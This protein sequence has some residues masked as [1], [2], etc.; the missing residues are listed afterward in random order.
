MVIN[1]I[2]EKFKNK[3]IALVYGQSIEGCGVTKVGAEIQKWCKQH[4]IQAD[5]YSYDERKY[6]RRDVHDVDF[7]SFEKDD[8]GN[9]VK[10]LNQYDIVM[11][12][13]YP[14]KKFPNESIKAFYEDLI[15]NINCIK[16]GFMHEIN[17]TNVDKIPFLVGIMNQM[18]LIYNF[19]QKT[20][21]S[22]NISKLLPSKDLGERV[23]KFSMLF[24]F[25][26]LKKY[27]DKISLNDKE[28]KLMY[29]G[30]W[31]TM[32]DP[33]R[34]LE[35]APILYNKDSN[36]KLE[37]CGLERSIGAYHDIFKQDNCLDKTRKKDPD[38][39][40]E[41]AVPVYGPYKYEEGMEKLA[42]SLFGCSFYRLPRTPENYG[43]RMEYTQIEIIAAGSIPVFDKHWGENNYIK[44]G[45]RFI[46]IP[47]SAIYSDKEDLEGTVNKLIE[48]ANDK[49]LQE[50]YRK[51]SYEIAKQ[52]F[53]INIVLPEILNHILEKGI[54]KNK[55]K[56]D[57]KLI[58]NLTSDC[59]DNEEFLK[60]F[61]EQKNKGEIV[62]M[63]IR[64]L[65][66]DNEVCVLGG[67]SG[68]K[69][70]KI[71]KFKKK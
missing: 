27:R 9:I 21:F 33:R 56:N 48:V 63:G 38:E 7:I 55:F 44:D 24:D 19:S 35:M 60:I 15:K 58:L 20:W 69:E 46:D 49:E 54:D 12:H 50:K 29:I 45:Q 57:D 10:E 11:F 26:E 65:G 25:D 41:N 3:K 6:N 42:N 61:N 2:M 22:Q 53:D 14:A 5:I 39:I 17:K 30:R 1:L 67:K 64:E 23:C 28:K 70:V 66:R 16:V 34:L 43:D 37:L 4:D 18:D 32:K 8:I 36:F 62:V 31:T 52:Q 13:S 59:E 71:K 68:R 40:P 47:Y 51:K